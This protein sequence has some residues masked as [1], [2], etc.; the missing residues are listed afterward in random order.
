VHEHIEA[1][2]AR[3][4]RPDNYPVTGFIWPVARLHNDR[5]LALPQ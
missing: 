1:E 3:L 4:K 5:W 2:L